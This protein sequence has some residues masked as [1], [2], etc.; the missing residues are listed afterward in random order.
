MMHSD[1]KVSTGT[2]LLVLKT[3]H[4][5]LKNI[6]YMLAIRE[7]LAKIEIDMSHLPKNRY[8]DL[9]LGG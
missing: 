9:K 1:W 5:A 6:L 2:L 7:N 4:F 3:D 8:L